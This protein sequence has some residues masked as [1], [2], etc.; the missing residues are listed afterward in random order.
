LQELPQISI[1]PASFKQKDKRLFY[2]TSRHSTFEDGNVNFLRLS[3]A[4]QSHVGWLF[5]T[6]YLSTPL[7]EPGTI[8]CKSLLQN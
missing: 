6:V 2:L 1:F 7:A 8:I 3:K 5:K 4:S